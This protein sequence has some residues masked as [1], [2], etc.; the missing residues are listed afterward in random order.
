MCMYV[1]VCAICV[2]AYQSVCLC[3]CVG[4]GGREARTACAKRPDQRRTDD[5]AI[6][7][8]ANGSK[9]LGIAH[10]KPWVGGCG[11]R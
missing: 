2:R 8:G 1:S 11:Q 10:A 4:R 9:L 5:D 3:M 7:Q 6:A